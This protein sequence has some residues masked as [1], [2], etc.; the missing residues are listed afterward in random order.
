MLIIS[1]VA[2]GNNL[3]HIIS[4]E[5]GAVLPPLSQLCIHVGHT[6]ELAVNDRTQLHFL[7][8]TLGSILEHSSECHSC[9]SQ[10]CVDCW[11]FSAG[12][13]LHIGAF[14]T[15]LNMIFTF[16]KVEAL[17]FCNPIITGSISCPE[18]TIF[19]DLSG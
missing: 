7:D 17:I 3:F 12:L 18:I 8:E 1:S 11:S 14:L 10:N 15:V 16:F 19:Q 6:S 5:I 4:S 9:T 2:L 13:P